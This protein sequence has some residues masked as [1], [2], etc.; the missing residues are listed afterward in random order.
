MT[1]SGCSVSGCCSVS[2][3]VLFG[4]TIEL[5][6]DKH[7][8]ARDL[9]TALPAAGVSSYYWTYINRELFLFGWLDIL[10]E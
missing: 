9:Q 4:S 2:T 6:S 5:R 8:D 1:F 3:D 7:R 10:K